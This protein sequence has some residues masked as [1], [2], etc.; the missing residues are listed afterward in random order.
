MNV[1]VTQLSS[2]L[3]C[4]P[5]VQ[6]RA[7]RRKAICVRRCDPGSP[8]AGRSDHPGIGCLARLL[9]TLPTAV[10]AP[11]RALQ[12]S[13][14]TVQPGKALRRYLWCVATSVMI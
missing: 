2:A 9:P 14:A 1:A 12:L 10:S 13:P 3:D 4:N 6:G 8:A 11:S 7:P 5:R